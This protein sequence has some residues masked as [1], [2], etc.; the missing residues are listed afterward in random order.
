MLPPTP[1]ALWAGVV[2]SL[3][4]SSLLG[5]VGAVAATVSTNLS[6][7]AY[8]FP[9]HLA[10][11]SLY[12]LPFC[13]NIVLAN[14]TLPR[15]VMCIEHAKN[16]EKHDITPPPSGCTNP[17]FKPRTSAQQDE[18]ADHFLD[19]PSCSDIHF[20]YSDEIQSAMCIEPVRNLT[21]D[22]PLKIESRSLPIPASEVRRE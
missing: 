10:N 22:E 12:R 1:V 15:D 14:G 3:T 17:L 7:A 9:C 18:V 6:A 20:P 16:I 19:P 11:E 5:G 2:S 21:L 4:A 8:D 13:S